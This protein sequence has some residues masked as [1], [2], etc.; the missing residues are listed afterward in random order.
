MMTIDIMN[1]IIYTFDILITTKHVKEQ[2]LQPIVCT[3][4]SF[5][6]SCR[7]QLQCLWDFVVLHPTPEAALITSLYLTPNM[8]RKC[9]KV[10]SNKI[11]NIQ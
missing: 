1:K 7:Q 3:A 11:S 2:R 5:F 9:L 10:Q 4:S 8:A 6:K